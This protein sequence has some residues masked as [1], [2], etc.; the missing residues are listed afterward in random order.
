M[1]AGARQ[2]DPEYILELEAI[3]RLPALAAHVWGHFKALHR[4]RGG[5]G[6][7]PAP[8]TPQILHYWQIER[9]RRLDTWERDAVY[10]I[11]A[12]YLTCIAERQEKDKPKG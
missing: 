11:D 2:G 1:E 5:T 9:G 8:L 3:P 12:A 6:F 10:A 7:G 4:T